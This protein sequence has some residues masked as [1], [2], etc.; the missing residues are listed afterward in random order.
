MSERRVPPLGRSLRADGIAFAANRG[1][2]FRFRLRR[3]EWWNVARLFVLSGDFQAMALYRLR[4][5]LR[6]AGVPIL[7]ALL[8][9]LCA[10]MFKSRIGDGVVIDPG[11]YVPHGSISIDGETSI[12]SGCVITPWVR[13]GPCARE[14]AGP[15]I[16]SGVFIGAHAT[17]RGSISVGRKA[18]IGAGA[19]VVSD[20][21]AYAVVAGVPAKVIGNSTAGGF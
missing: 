6:Q 13:I 15:T 9:E 18:Q 17:I 2:R 10:W 19:Q 14:T 11:V 8:R 4:S 20:V 3:E 5:T 21:P 1:E 16:E 7:P 12:G